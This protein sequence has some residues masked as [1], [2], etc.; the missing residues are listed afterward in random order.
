MTQAAI[1][2]LYWQSALPIKQAL[3]KAKYGSEVNSAAVKAV[4][5][6]E[7]QYY[8][9][10]MRGLPPTLARLGNLKESLM[11]STLAVKGK[12]P[13]KASDVQLPQQGPASEAYLIFPRTQAFTADD[14]EVEFSAKI[15]RSTIKTKFRLKDMMYNSKLEM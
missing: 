11:Q 3:L 4:L 1:V 12:D 15:A 8:V 9:L 5:D 13:V 7:E 14:K 2:T 10:V 6:R